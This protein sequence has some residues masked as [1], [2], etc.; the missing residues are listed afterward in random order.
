MPP[1]PLLTRPFLLLLIAQASFGFSFASFFLLPKF[2]TTALGGAPSQIGLVMASF[3]ATSIVAIPLVGSLV[4]RLGRKRFVTA[5]ALVMTL[6]AL[7]FLRVDRVGPLLY[8][9]RMLQGIGFAMAFIAASTMVTDLAPRERL[10]QALGVFGISILSMH[11]I[12]PAVAEEIASRAGWSA[13][14][15]TAAAGAA[16]CVV[17]TSLLEDRRPGAHAGDGASLLAVAMRPRSLRIT[18]VVALTGAAFGVMMTYPQPFALGLGR[19]H[20]RGFFLAYATAAVAMRLVL[21]GTADRIGRHRVSIASLA[22]YGAVVTGMAWMRA[23]WL[24]PFG[25]V[26]GAAH[27][28]FYPA[29]NA[30]AVEAASPD[31]RGKVMAL[32]NGGFNLGNSSATL[33]LGFVAERFGFPV[34]FLIAGAGVALA[35]ALLVASPEGKSAGSAS[36]AASGP[37]ACAR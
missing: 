28:L 15:G 10:G 4:D 5:G 19:T 35:L 36:L 17:L 25:L 20:V 6:A 1:P 2:V 11:A 26:F 9:L 13:V 24:E 33:A 30:L 14:F 37:S 7:A 12:A 18:S 29:F 34:V 21:G 16:L 22:V 23:S 3:G 32:F 8:G 31:E 27:G